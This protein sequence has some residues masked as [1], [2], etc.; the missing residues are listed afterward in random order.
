M[1]VFAVFVLGALVGSFL[2]V[3]IHRLPSGE[4]IV[5][6]ASHCPHCQAA[7][8]PYDNV[9]VLSY[10]ILRGRC[11]NCATPIALR[12]PVVEMLGGLAAVGAVLH[13]GLT[14]M[15]LI[16]FA[17]LAALIVVTFIDIDHQIIPNEISLPG[18]GVGFAAAVLLGQPQWLDSLL[19]IVLGGG[20]LWIVAASYAFVTKREG[21]GGGDI[22]LLAMIGAF[23]GWRGV[24]VTVL[25]GSLVGS[26]I[27][28]GIMLMRRDD[29]KMAIPFGPFLAAGAVCALF[30]SEPIID[31]YL[32]LG[33][34]LAGLVG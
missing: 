1:L 34:W 26:I 2:N 27:G 13:A 10:L 16:D 33:D 18:I 31:W 9:P 5:F 12:Y 6:P 22:K 11:R 21:M 4:S 7:I 3:C 32:H 30:W 19:G 20:I 14:A 15:A 17:F 8:A 29:A 23:V 25:L 28:M 24:L